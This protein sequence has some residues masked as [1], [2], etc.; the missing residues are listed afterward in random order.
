MSGHDERDATTLPGPAV[1]PLVVPPDLRG[2]TIGLPTEYFPADLDPGTR[3]GVERTVALI[4]E[5]GARVVDVSLPHS[6]YAV[7]TYYILA[8]AEASANLARYDGVR[9]GPPRPAGLPD[10][11]ALYQATRGRGFGP[12]VRRRILIGT[13]VL[14][15]GYYEAYYGKAQRMRARIAEDFT[16]VFASGVDLLF[17]PTTPT[18]AFRAGEKTEDPVQMYLADVFVCAVSLAGLPGLSLPVGR[19]GGLPLGGQL[20]APYAADERMLSA[21]AVLERHLDATAEV[22]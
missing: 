9:Y 15:A 10:V 7:P 8:P 2:L 20:I 22:R 6:P 21:A 1:A 3:A 17:T 18:P 14:S 12:E 5:L 16:R 19:S 11:R 13:Y 4:R